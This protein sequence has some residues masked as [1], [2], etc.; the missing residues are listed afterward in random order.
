MGLLHGAEEPRAHGGLGSPWRGTGRAR[1][2]QFTLALPES[3]TRHPRRASLEYTFNTLFLTSSHLLAMLSAFQFL[4]C[5]LFQV[6]E[7]LSALGLVPRALHLKPFLQEYTRA[8]T[9]TDTELWLLCHSGKCQHSCCLRWNVN[10][11]CR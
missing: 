1:W 11:Y 8:H 4:F 2:F 3:Q 7:L 9:H 6:A 5:F 10:E